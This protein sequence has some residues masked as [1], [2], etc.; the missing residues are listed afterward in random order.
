MRVL[1][2]AIAVLRDAG[3]VIA[4]VIIW[5]VITIALSVPAF[6]V[7]SPSAIGE[8]FV[9]NAGRIGAALAQTG[10]EAAAGFAGGNL[11]GLILAILFARSRRLERLGLPVAIALRSVPLIAIAPL[12]TII[13]GFGPSTIVVMAVLISFFPALVAGSA[14]LR[15]PSAEALALMRVLDAPEHVRFLRLRIPAA[16][17]F[18]FAAF[19]ITAP[20]AVLAAMVAEWTAANSG[21]GYLIIDAGEQYRFPLMW[22]GIVAATALAVGAFIVASFAERRVIWWPLEPS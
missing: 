9:A 7:P 1:R 15:A 19:K 4:F 3:A 6:L 8:A 14:G 2:P 13:L 22:A 5:Q 20:A 11:L 18:V 12:L 10:A 17:P 16:L 21:L